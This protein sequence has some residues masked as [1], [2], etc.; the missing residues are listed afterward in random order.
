M[1]A[2]AM[3]MAGGATLA[4]LAACATPAPRPPRP[5]EVCLTNRT[6]APA[7]VHVSTDEANRGRF[8]EE[9]YVVA[10][11]E[12]GCVSGFTQFTGPM[13]VRARA[14]QAMPRRGDV[15]SPEGWLPCAVI[16]ARRGQGVRGEYELVSDD[17][18]P[19][20]PLDAG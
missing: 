18:R 4:T 6:P 5:L 11:G 10:P 19:C 3:V 15:L 17:R 8:T 16:D 14:N 9:G 2:L 1:H 20:R 13:R 12:R 7:M